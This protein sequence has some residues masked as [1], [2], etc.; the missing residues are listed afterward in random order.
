MRRSERRLQ[1]AADLV[2]LC[3]YEWDLTKAQ[4]IWGARQKQMWGLPPDAHVDREVFLSAIHPD[5]RPVVEAAHERAFDPNGDGQYAAEYRVIGIQDGVERWVT[6]RGCMFFD[7]GKP[8]E[9]LGTVMEITE[10]KRLEREVLEIS[11]R[12]RLRI[13]QDLHDDLCQQ[14]TSIAFTSR[15]LQQRL[16]TRSPSEAQ[17][18]EEIVQAVQ[19]LTARTRDL[20]KGLH[21]V[22][23]ETNGLAATLRE[24]ATTIESVFR[25]TCRFRHPPG[26]SSATISDPTVA[27][28][29]YRIAQEAATNAVK[30]GRAK[31]ISMNL[32][33]VRGRV[34]LSIA[35]DGSGIALTPKRQGMG[36]QIMHQR[37]HVIG[38]TLS[39]TR[40]QQGGT[41][42]TCS[43]ASVS[44]GPKSTKVKRRDVVCRQPRKK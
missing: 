28:Q 40:R 23:L 1:L 2:G 12:E 13:G 16:A 30:H 21:P 17:V 8:V 35:D 38:A 4:P 41:L 15:L 20:A 5:D 6:A 10:R 26:R 39:I 19:Q 36:L 22:R 31:N 14:L 27:I 33:M 7:N 9:Y 24:L 18:A 43:F 42:V 34:E 44:P 11:E 37:A 25:V 3:H 32:N 29:L